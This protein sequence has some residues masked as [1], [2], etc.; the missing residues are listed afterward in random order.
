MV[1]VTEVERV[2]GSTVRV[3]FGGE[4]GEWINEPDFLSWDLEKC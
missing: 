1:P 3:R 2:P 4:D